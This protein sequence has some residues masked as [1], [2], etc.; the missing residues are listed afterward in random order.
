M[1]LVMALA[2]EIGA[3]GAAAVTDTSTVDGAASPPHVTLPPDVEAKLKAFL[4]K[5]KLEKQKIWEGRMRL[6]IDHVVKVTGLDEDHAKSLDGPAKQ[7]IAECLDPWETR[8]DALFRPSLAQAAAP[9]IAQ[10][11]AENPAQIA[12]SAWGI[13][14]PQPYDQDDWIKAVHQALTPDQAATWD[15]EETDHQAEV[16]K[17]IS[18]A[19]DRGSDRVIVMQ[20]Q[21]ITSACRGIELALNLPKDRADKLEALG[22][23]VAGQAK[24]KWQKRFHGT[25]R[26]MG[27]DQLRMFSSNPNI[28]IGIQPDEY[29]SQ[30]P[31]WKKNLA[32]F[33]T[34]DEAARLKVA[35]DTRKAKREHVTSQIMLTLLDSKVALT[36]AQRTHLLPL[37]DRL[38]K[39]GPDLFPDA[40]AGTYFA[41]QP[42]MFYAAAAKATDADLKPV[43]DDIQLKRW[44]DLTNPD[45][46]PSNGADGDT[47]KADDSFEPEDV[48]KA[49]SAYLFQKTEDQRKRTLG[50][51]VLK[52]EDAVRTAKLSGDAACRL[53]AAAQGATERSLA[54][55]KWTVEQQV[56]GQLQ[57]NLTPQNIK[58]R[59]DGIQDFIFQQNFGIMR[60]NQ[61]GQRFDF[62][63]AAMKTLT[64]P[65]QDAW[66]KETDARDA[67]HDQAVAALV[68]AEFDR[69]YQLTDDQWQKLQP[70]I[71]GIVRDISADISQMFSN[72]ND[73][74]WFLTS[75]FTLMPFAGL[76]DTD[77]KSIL[78]KEQLDGWT[79]SPDFSNASSWW[80]NIKQIH[81]QRA[82]MAH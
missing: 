67:F 59:L 12:Q 18:A 22:N 34:S 3:R 61:G 23:D 49:I 30:L 13:D 62:W 63:D 42:Q 20:K 24:E 54:M 55:W 7:A 25:L 53:E 48:E 29:P 32:S 40:A 56:R 57:D 52:A 10:I 77:L 78:T 46:A 1:A 51:N 68:L 81:Q 16:D 2:I 33:L 5:A 31:E 17:Q 8:A 11:L 21:D 73:T 4:D 35:H 14:S 36:E 82:Q 58:Q 6:E 80:T 71:A 72:G 26:D 76:A 69:Q 64:Q 50:D 74:P 27:D 9:Q 66:K 70:L 15:K 65:Q 39:D 60:M 28:F 41:I 37:T 45:S 75:Q 47:A 19:I 38:A 79:G 44:H 43:L